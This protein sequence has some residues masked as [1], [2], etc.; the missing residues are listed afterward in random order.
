[1]EAVLLLGLL[2]AQPGMS[3]ALR[4]V[5]P[6]LLVGAAA[7]ALGQAQASSV[8]RATLGQGL[9]R[10]PPDNIRALGGRCKCLTS[11][12]IGCGQRGSTERRCQ[13]HPKPSCRC[14]GA[15]PLM[16][17]WLYLGPV[18][19]CHSAEGRQREHA[20][21]SCVSAAESLCALACARALV[22]SLW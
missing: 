13:R 8:P 20:L 18:W 10:P 22:R 9:R 1:M 5:L 21:A 7:V 4:L 11:P 16:H 6:Q 17:A 12:R 15:G 19:L 2:E 3:P 14:A